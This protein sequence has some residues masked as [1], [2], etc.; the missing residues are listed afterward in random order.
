MNGLAADLMISRGLLILIFSTIFSTSCVTTRY[1]S[2]SEEKP[3]EV[4]Y[5]IKKISDL[6]NELIETSGLE[7]IAGNILSFNDSGGEPVIYS[8][9]P[10]NSSLS[11]FP[12]K[13]A[14]NIDWEDMTFDGE[15]LFIGDFGNNY[16]WRDTLTVYKIDSDSLLGSL[17]SNLHRIKYIYSEKQ[18][19]NKPLYIRS[20]FDAEAMAV[21]NDSLY[22]F[23][24]NWN[25]QVSSWVYVL[26]RSEGYS[27]LSRKQILFPGFMVCGA[28]Y[29]PGIKT[30]YFCGY[31]KFVPYVVILPGYSGVGDYPENM[32]RIKMTRLFGVQT[33]GIVSDRNGNIYISAEKSRQRQSLYILR[34]KK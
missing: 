7:F 3:A 29:D 24:K 25:D 18:D 11:A 33:E 15:H 10:G 16:G 17:T 8:F 1:I 6:P 20:E 23:T 5:K 19:E 32:I 28:D 13:G 2:I 12:V 31:K 27:T 4:R 21:I 14:D 26:A 34:I 30:L 22:I 9:N